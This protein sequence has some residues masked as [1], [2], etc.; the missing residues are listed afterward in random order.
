MQPQIKAGTS[1][2]VH[3]NAGH[4]SLIA[5]RIFAPGEL[6]LDVKGKALKVASRY[7]IQIDR[8][9]HI[10]PDALPEG[11]SGYDHYLWP[12][13]N[14]SFEPNTRMSGRALIAVKEISVGDE[15]TFDYNSNEWDMA[16]PFQCLKTGRWV[17]GYKHLNTQERE[18]LHE[19]TAPFLLELASEEPGT[20]S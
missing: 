19:L 8:D 7:S 6:I 5:K 12:F 4:R 2:D 16:T 20:D 1:V 13:L 17:R 11:L 3:D 10:E 18:Q 15:V 14:H 9:I